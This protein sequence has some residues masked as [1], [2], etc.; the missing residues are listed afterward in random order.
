MKTLFSIVAII[1]LLMGSLSA[2]TPDF[3]PNHDVVLCGPNDVY[4]VCISPQDPQN[5]WWDFG[6]GT[7]GTGLTP[8]HFYTTT[9]VYDVKLIT[10]KNGVKDSITKT[11]FV[12]V[13]P[14]PEARFERASQQIHE[15]FKREFKFTGFSNA[16]SMI[17]YEWKVNDTLAAETKDFVHVFPRSDWFR[18]SL[19]VTNNKGCSASATDSLFISGVDIAGVGEKLFQKDFKIGLT[20]DQHILSIERLSGANEKLNVTVYDITGKAEF[21]GLLQ[22]GD[23]SWKLDVSSLQP[24]LHLVVVSNRS[25]MATRKLQKYML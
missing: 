1:A 19:N 21:T 18:I 13:N 23:H 16:D 3:S 6:D 20:P 5:T 12:I 22:E 9:G 14:V 10:E 17:S 15:P 7:T 11:A 8:T 24:G 25:Y 4:F 2:Q